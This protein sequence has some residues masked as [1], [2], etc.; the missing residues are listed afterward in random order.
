MQADDILKKLKK[1]ASPKN[2]EGM[3]RFGIKPKKAIGVS[4][5]NL[6]KL[7]KEIGKDHVLAQELWD[8]GIHEAKILASMIDKI[9]LVTKKQMDSWIKDF[10]SWDV[11]DQVCMNLFDKTLFAFEKAIAWT[12]N[13]LEFERRAGFALMASLAFH[14]KTFS[15]EKFLD[16]FPFIKKYSFDERNYVRKSVNWALRQIGKRNIN[17]NKLAIEKAKEILKIDSKSAKWIAS[18]AIRELTSEAIQTRLKKV[19]R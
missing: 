14:N 6:R 7:A 11:C 3:A 1:L 16:F 12:K 5:P 17:L 19:C 18:D 4:I 15:D 10:D 8:S 2:I 13:E 9:E